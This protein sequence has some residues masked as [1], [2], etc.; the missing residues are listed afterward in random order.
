MGKK[1]HNV[2]LLLLTF[3]LLSMYVVPQ[4][5]SFRAAAYQLNSLQDAL[6]IN[7]A[8]R[9]LHK[10]RYLIADNSSGSLLASTLTPSTVHYFTIKFNKN[11]NNTNF[12]T[13]QDQT[14]KY[15]TSHLNDNNSSLTLQSGSVITNNQ[16]FQ[17]DQ[18]GDSFSFKQAGSGQYVY[19]IGVPRNHN[20]FELKMYYAASASDSEK[21][22][23][24]TLPNTQN[25]IY[26][27]NLSILEITE[28]GQSDLAKLKDNNGILA[29]KVRTMSMKS[30]V[31]DRSALDG[32]YDVIYI[33]K[34]NYSPQLPVDYYNDLQNGVIRNI[35]PYPELNTASL[36]NDITQLKANELVEQFVEKGQ[37]VV[38][39]RQILN[40]NS[41]GKLKSTFAKYDTA[42]PRSNVVF[43]DD[44]ALSSAYQFEQATKLSSKGYVRSKFSLIEQPVDYAKQPYYLY[45]AGDKLNFNI[46]IDPSTY[47]GNRAL[48][49]RLSIQDGGSTYF[50]TE[51][52]VAEQEVQQQEATISYT[53]P[54]GFSGIRYWRLELIDPLNK[55]KDLKEGVVRFRDYKPQIRVL[56]AM[57]N[58]YLDSNLNKTMPGNYLNTD[59]YSVTINS[60]QIE[61]N[62]GLT[63]N[64]HYYKLLNGNYDMLIFGFRDEYHKDGYLINDSIAALKA[65][66]KTGQGVM[67]TH[68]TMY[69]AMNDNAWVQNFLS[70]V[71][72]IRP[73]TN[74]GHFAQE[75]TT[76]IDL[77]NSGLLTQFPF[78]I[79][80]ASYPDIKVAETHSQ[81][82][83]LDLENPEVTNWFTLN[84]ARYTPRDSWNNYYTYSLHNITYSGTG[85]VFGTSGNDFPSWEK[86]VFINTMYRGFIGA[87]HAPLV[88]VHA[89][90]AYSA[91]ADN[92]I[93]SYEPTITV[94]YTATDYDLLDTELKTSLNMI[95]KVNGTD[96]TQPVITNQKMVSG[97]TMQFAVNNPLQN[98]TAGAQQDITF[99]IIAVDAAGAM[100]KKTVTVRVKH[101][102]ANL[103]LS[104]SAASTHFVAGS[105]NTVEK[106]QPIELTYTITPKPIVLP[107][108][109]AAPVINNVS[110][111]E[112][113]P[114][115]I[116]VELGA[117]ASGLAITTQANGQTKV[118][119]T[120][121]AGSITYVKGATNGENATF[122]AAPL[123][124]KLK[125]RADNGNYM[126][127]TARLSFT[128]YN[129]AVISSLPFP[130]Y[131]FHALTLVEE[132]S[133]N[134]KQLL[135]GDEAKLIPDIQEA[136]MP[137]DASNKNVKYESLNPA[138]VSVSPLG[139]IKGLQPG[140]AT[141]KV[142][143]LDGSNVS[144][145]AKI[146]VIEP[147]L[148]IVG[149][150]TVEIGRAI[151]LEFSFSSINEELDSANQEITW[152]APSNTAVN[153]KSIVSIAAA[154]GQAGKLN[155]TGKTQGIA[156]IRLELKVRNQYTGNIKTYTAT[157]TVEVVAP[158][159]IL[160]DVIRIQ[161]AGDGGS[162]TRNLQNDLQVLPQQ[163]KSLILDQLNW[164]KTTNNGIG[165]IHA[166]TG[167]FTATKT[168]YETIRV[169]YSPDASVYD[170]VM[171]I[172]TRAPIDPDQI[173]QPG[174]KY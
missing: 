14:G 114:Q 163:A 99:E 113:F 68:D 105:S 66:I 170:E 11:V 46:Y 140:T 128:D 158:Q 112:F 22:K 108:N 9:S 29:S 167:Q 119:G 143:A 51:H 89:P 151:A 144:A 153:G 98:L 129:R 173:H 154:S 28:N 85:H 120:V 67:F 74:F 165:S 37:L 110:F 133:L 95:Y 93:A 56:Q 164:S 135:V 130:S 25:A 18:H 13:I 90:S 116:S 145:T 136:I 70:T 102:N 92:Y 5:T 138:I 55:R 122:T 39:H 139:V 4:D 15:I 40:Q 6:N 148:I 65:F 87:N 152:S 104:R 155:V 24:E 80:Q 71:G 10:D 101:V 78:F 72:Q 150:D 166:T 125:I 88:E 63:Y 161:L 84:S 75:K 91:A 58:W 19:Y 34:G 83:T 100:S 81:Y 43:I 31:A 157:H 94:R 48:T 142:S 30:F 60:I 172:V 162:T 26:G 33:G 111:E 42:E 169:S 121:Q 160:P 44:L 50:K 1:I 7:V 35:N 109:A 126:L 52:I 38:L 64:N 73:Y 118:A 36:Q 45:H 146:T 168:G 141:I 32:V 171:I 86:Q 12:Y 137:K 16:L 79:E 117:N 103:E 76:N 124:F 27:S 174:G 127:D 53:L 41:S 156:S 3:L 77:V 69:A 20:Q 123:S 17:I 8:L 134:D 159:L 82:Y 106:N 2:Y 62:N 23:L 132:I 61:A 96:V 54:K 47:S 21:F 149:P 49:L 107:K 115:G 131:S 57:P 59:D 97:E 147:G